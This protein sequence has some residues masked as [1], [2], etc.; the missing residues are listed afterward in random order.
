MYAARAAGV[1][2]ALDVLDTLGHD[3][4]DNVREAA[5]AALIELKRPE[6]IPLAIEDLSRAGLSADHHGHARAGRA[7][8]RRLER[9]RRC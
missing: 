9:R 6:A 1:L 5:L 7:R 2:A 3:R 8:A 4:V